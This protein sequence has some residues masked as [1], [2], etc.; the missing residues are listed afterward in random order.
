M[1]VDDRWSLFRS[2]L[3]GK[4][5]IEGLKMCSSGGRCSEVVVSSCLTIPDNQTIICYVI[6]HRVVVSNKISLLVTFV[7]AG[8]PK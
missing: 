6:D 8:T 1:A 3:S 2:H 4:I 7:A 5:T